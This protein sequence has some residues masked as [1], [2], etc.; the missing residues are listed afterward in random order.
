M[1]KKR[2]LDR[3]IESRDL[4]AVTVTVFILSLS[5]S[6]RAQPVN[7]VIATV[8]I[9][10][11]TLIGLRVTPDGK[12]VYVVGWGSN[13]VFVIDTATN[14][15]APNAIG[16]GGIAYPNFLAI[17]PKGNYVYAANAHYGARAAANAPPRTVSTLDNPPTSPPHPK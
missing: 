15:E 3:S 12:Y 9:N 6:L 2:L 14:T 13:A 4:L 16:L 5:F 10:S 11:G 7:T 8:P 1:K 17:S